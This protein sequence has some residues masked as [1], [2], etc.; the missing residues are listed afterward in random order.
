[1][2]P[3]LFNP[4]RKHIGILV[5]VF[6]V[7]SI[8]YFFSSI[9]Y[10]LD[11]TDSFYHLNQALHPANDIYLY[12]FFLSSVIIKGI[13]GFVGPEIIHLRFLNS[14]MLFFSILIPFFIIKIKKPREEVLFYIACGLFLFTPFNVNILGYDSISI[15]ILSLIFSLSVLYLQKANLYVLLLLSFLCSLAI[16]VRLPNL[17]VVPIVLSVIGISG[18][19]QTGHFTW[20]PAVLYLGLTLLL[21]F[22]GFSLYYAN[23]EEFYGASANSSSHDLKILFY[24]YFLHGLRIL[25]F[26]TLILGGYFA[27]KKSG[28]KIP[29]WVIYAVTGLFFI[30]LIGVFVIRSKYSQNYSLFL[31]AFALSIIIVQ[32]MRNR[33]NLLSIQ[34]L[35][36]Y[37]YVLFLFINPFG[38]NTGLLKAASLFLLLPFVLSFQNLKPDKYWLLILI[39]LLPFSFIEKLSGTYEDDGIPLLNTTLTI[40]ALHPVKTTKTRAAFLEKINSEI[41]ELKK[42]NVEVYFYGDKSHIFHYLYPGTNLNINSF[43][44]PIDELVYYPKIEQIINKKQRVAIFI[45]QSYPGNETRMQHIVG[46]ELLNDGFKKIK[47]ESFDYYLRIKTK[48]ISR[49]NTDYTDQK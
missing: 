45:I 34:N 47:T 11:F 15:F 36:L 32:I 3:F 28:R 27:F 1:L 40:P 30:I 35:V 23:F 43:F 12:P 6:L 10:G 16:L 17:L 7:I 4:E 8:L 9:F 18:K 19:I 46:D 31:T 33:K 2:K 49:I 48:K 26:I 14:L 25:L 13:I 21:V 37:L 41:R 22:F 5:N 44:Q 38:S 24:N 29:K 39:V 20:K 42:N